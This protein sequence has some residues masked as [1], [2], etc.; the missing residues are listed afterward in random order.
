MNII[1][2]E[3]AKA[4]PGL[5]EEGRDIRNWTVMHADEEKGTFVVEWE[6]PQ[7]GGAT[8]NATCPRQPGSNRIKTY[9]QGES[10][11]NAGPLQ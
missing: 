1:A 11:K 8:P 2:E 4:V 3:A 5:L 10:S 7:D 6:T 9:L